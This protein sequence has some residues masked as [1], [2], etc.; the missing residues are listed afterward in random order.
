MTQI[1]EYKIGKHLGSGAYASV[2]L[3]I[4]QKTGLLVAIKVY[5][6]KKLKEASR[7]KSVQRE[8]LLLKKLHHKNL[9]ILFD[10]IESP[11]QFY[12]VMEY[13]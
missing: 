8:S 13:V 1:A 11:S 2:K 10:A 12:L 7:K 4:H 9:P 6:K 3:A 5:D